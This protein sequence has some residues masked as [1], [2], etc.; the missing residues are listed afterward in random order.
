[1]KISLRMLPLALLVLSPLHAMRGLVEDSAG[2]GLSGVEVRASWREEP[3]TTDVFGTWTLEDPVSVGERAKAGV[4][5]ISEGLVL[6]LEAPSEVEIESFDPRGARSRILRRSF[7]AGRTVIAIPQSH[8]SSP[9]FLRVQ[10]DGKLWGV[11]TR[12]QQDVPTAAREAGAIHALSF[13]KDGYQ[14]LLRL[15]TPG[16]DTVRTVLWKIPVRKM[17]PVEVLPDSGVRIGWWA[18][19]SFRS[20]TDSAIFF[21]TLDGS[22]P[23]WDTTSLNPK[24]GTFWW[25]PGQARILLER[26][27]WLTVVAARKGW[28]PSEIYRGRFVFIGDSALVANFE[29]TGL[30][31]SEGGTGL[32][33]FACQYANGEGCTQDQVYSPERTMPRL[34]TLEESYSRVLGTRAWRIQVSMN[35]H[36][37]NFQAAY[38][39]GGIRLPPG[40]ANA[41]YRLVFWAKWQDTTIRGPATL[42][43]LVELATQQNA[44]NNGG[45][46]DGFHRR[47]ESVTRSWKRYEIDFGQFYAAGNGYS[48]GSSQ[49][50][51]TS[52]NP[53]SQALFYKDPSMHAL[54]L[55]GWQGHVWHNRFDPSWTWSVSKETIPLREDL[56]GFRFSVM[57]PMSPDAAETV[58]PVSPSW[59]DPHEH[60][61]SQTQ[62]DAL[63]KGIGGY[64]WIDE[65]RL[66]RKAL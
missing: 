17:A 62:V 58:G 22:S 28:V 56:V 36:G 31:G 34:D 54:G 29:G 21:Y 5:W 6:D 44:N 39:G 23:T 52:D 10:R 43:F 45:Y 50:D 57:Q 20:A 27:A 25:R 41:A 47:V 3:E 9:R 40:Y 66:V 14:D 35:K 13:H 65:V 59:K 26:S 4:S 61:L 30:S 1:M 55:S 64:L 49:P 15:V 48:P 60:S 46:T 24:A 7:P 33:W 42:P 19:I 16:Q 8:P 32:S 51:S 38:A 53:R 63:V 2:D 18:E 37:E 11:A 12:S